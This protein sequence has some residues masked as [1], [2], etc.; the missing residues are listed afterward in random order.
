MPGR[1][2]SLCFSCE[3]FWCHVFSDERLPDAGTATEGRGDRVASDG[4]AD[5]GDREGSSVPGGG[6]ACGHPA[7]PAAAQRPG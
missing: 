5:A 1:R 4:A 3:R 7:A 6:E 2:S